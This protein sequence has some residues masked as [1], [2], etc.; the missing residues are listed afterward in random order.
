MHV[1]PDPEEKYTVSWSY[2]LAIVYNLK[3]GTRIAWD[4]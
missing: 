1:R 3:E 2:G 4:F